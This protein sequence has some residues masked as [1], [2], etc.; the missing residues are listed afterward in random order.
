MS[1]V[2]QTGEPA[3][4]H[5]SRLHHLRHPQRPGCPR[6]TNEH[7]HCGFCVRRPIGLVNPGESNVIWSQHIPGGLLG[8]LFHIASRRRSLP[9]PRRPCAIPRLVSR[10]RQ[11]SAY[12]VLDR[13]LGDRFDHKAIPGVLA[14]K[15]DVFD[16]VLD[17]LEELRATGSTEEKPAG[18]LCPLVGDKGWTS[19]FYSGGRPINFPSGRVVLPLL[20]YAH[21]VA[22]HNPLR[23]A[24]R[25]RL[26]VAREAA[27]GID[28]LSYVLSEL[29]YIRPLVESEVLILIEHSPAELKS[30]D[31]YLTVQSEF[32][33]E[34]LRSVW[35]RY[36]DVQREQFAALELGWDE[37][38]ADPA[39]ENFRVVS[40]A[41][42]M[43]MAVARELPGVDLWL[44]LR[45]QVPIAEHVLRRLVDPSEFDS[46]AIQ[47]VNTGRIGSLASV[48]LPTIGDLT[49]ADIVAIR[50]NEQIFEDWRATLAQ[51]LVEADRLANSSGVVSMAVVQ[52]FMNSARSRLD[53][54]TRRRRLNYVRPT[55]SAFA[56]GSFGTIAASLLYGGSLGPSL[57]AGGTSAAASVT[58]NAASQLRDRRAWS[59]LRKHYSI[60]LGD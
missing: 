57:V 9:S 5:E 10:A 53:S 13:H 21:Q 50:R 26:G 42:C 43:S 28:E 22:I 25:R 35:P 59:A 16:A 36:D 52:D 11:S 24:I 60:V 44:P 14:W 23:L 27:H 4:V 32:A 41:T 47:Q 34:L 38:P 45:L 1:G 17:D 33:P 20:L 12:A 49:F 7:E 8:A 2:R 29:A 15:S 19:S 48:E 55:L 3:S 51:A 58:A 56:L 6:A 31:L 40:T 37:P 46:S 18:R 39:L 30:P 54:S